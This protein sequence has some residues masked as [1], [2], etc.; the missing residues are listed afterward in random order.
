MANK[1]FKKKHSRS[2]ELTESTVNTAKNTSLTGTDTSRVEAAIIDKLS[3]HFGASFEEATKDQVYK[4]TAITVKDILLA[5]KREFKQANNKSGGKRVYYLCMEFLVGR[6]L[7]NNLYN[8]GLTDVYSDIL[9]KYG[10]DL[11]ELYEMEPDAGLGNGGLGRLAACFMDSLAS[12]NYPA[13]GFSI[14]YEYGLFRQKIVE[15]WQMELP[16]VWLPGGEVWLS[17][18]TDKTFIVK[19]GGHINE[20]WTDEGL[21]I[22]QADCEEVEAVPYDMMISGADSKGVSV[23]RVW[24]S[25]D[26]DTFDMNSFSRGDYARAT[27]GNNKAELISKVLYPRDSHYEGKELRLKQQYFL[28]S[29]SA[30]NIIA[31]HMKYYSSLDNFADKVAIHIN[32]THPA[33]IVPE[34]MRIFM[35]EHHYS[36]DDAFN[37]ISKTLA[38]TNHTCLAEALEKWPENMMR[39]LLPRIYQIIHELNERH[40]KRIYD[41]F[42]GDWNKCAHMSIISGGVIHMAN[43]SIMGSHSV[44]VT[45]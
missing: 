3:R 9:K 18:R 5:K 15:G 21:I 27:L 25:R 41:K 35:D 40:C 26:I 33:M 14:L 28:V 34:L 30:Q 45:F 43:L 31:D 19:F 36:W 4:A 24:R 44:R 6:S 23:L 42:S 8:L 17:P 37:I 20:T 32:D 7:K 22:E 38:Y 39:R 12:L 2:K 1:Q 10:Y 11:N 13:T 16:D 29:A